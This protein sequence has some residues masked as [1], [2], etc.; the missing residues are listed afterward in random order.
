MTTNPGLNPVLYDL[1]Y[2]FPSP[3]LKKAHPHASETRQKPP[4]PVISQIIDKL[5]HINQVSSHAAYHK[6]CARFTCE[7]YS[8]HL[9]IIVR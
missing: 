7:L 3:S 9:C 1:F 2:R 6:A 4:E 8:K 5:K